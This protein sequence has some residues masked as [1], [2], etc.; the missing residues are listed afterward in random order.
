[1]GF[2]QS[3]V[4]ITV[5]ASGV[6]RIRSNH[7]FELFAFRLVTCFN[8]HFT[9]EAIESPGVSMTSAKPHHPQHLGSFYPLYVYTPRAVTRSRAI[10]RKNVQR[11][12]PV[13]LYSITV[14]TNAASHERQTVG[15][16]PG[17][18]GWGAGGRRRRAVEPFEE[19]CLVT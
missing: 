2:K 6:G 14:E 3:L 1:M 19:Q 11:V 5:M 18:G 13:N 10:P 9:N 15:Q 12:R 8:S 17:G 7:Q 4:H 16:A